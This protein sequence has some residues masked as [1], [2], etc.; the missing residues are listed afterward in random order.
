MVDAARRMWLRHDLKRFSKAEIQKEFR[1]QGLYTGYADL[2]LEGPNG[3]LIVDWK[4]TGRPRQSFYEISWQGRFYSWAFQIPNVSYR[5]VARDGALTQVNLCFDQDDWREAMNQLLACYEM[6]RALRHFPF[7]PKVRDESVCQSCRFRLQCFTNQ[8]PLGVPDGQP[9]H[10]SYSSMSILMHC[11]EK[12][13]RRLWTGDQED[14]FDYG[15]AMGKLFEIGIS[16][17]Y[18]EAFSTNEE[19]EEH[20]GKDA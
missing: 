17:V 19:H 6:I 18:S 11:P 9:D 20:K 15:I 14:P 3:A 7:W 13:R 5:I 10:L 16:A 8:E 2:V 1:I 12:F 4:T